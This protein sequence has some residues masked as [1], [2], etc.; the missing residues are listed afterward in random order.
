MSIGGL[1]IQGE[2]TRPPVGLRVFS[3]EINN[4]AETLPKPVLGMDRQGKWMEILLDEGW[5][6][7]VRRIMKSAGHKVVWLC[8]V[9]IGGLEIRIN[10]TLKPREW[11]T[12]EK[13]DHFQGVD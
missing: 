13:Q 5:N 6:R 2:V 8:R 12:S 4:V 7:Q 3:N 10:L 1:Q 11:K 9:A